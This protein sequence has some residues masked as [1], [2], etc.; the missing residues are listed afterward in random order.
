[1]AQGQ[2][3]HDSS[4]A[5]SEGDDNNCLAACKNATQ[6]AASTGNNALLLAFDDIDDNIVSCATDDPTVQPVQ[7]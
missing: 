1:M 4:L 3:F 2:N 5:A 6:V 7:H